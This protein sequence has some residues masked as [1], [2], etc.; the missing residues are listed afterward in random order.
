M[1]ISIRNHIIDNFKESSTNDFKDSINDSID[2]K[3]E[4]TLPGLGV[5]FELLWKN[6][7]DKDKNKI[8][9]VIND[10]IKAY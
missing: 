5:F 9:K 7:S 2:D 1:N 3:D 4:V 8:I 10:S 6:S